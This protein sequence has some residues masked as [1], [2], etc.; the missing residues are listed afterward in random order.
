MNCQMYAH[1]LTIWVAMAIAATACT[2]VVGTTL[3][4]KGAAHIAAVLSS[5]ATSSIA[6]LTVS[7]SAGDGPSFSTMV[8]D[9]AQSGSSWTA[10]VTGIPSGS[11]RRFDVVAFDASGN[12]LY[13]GTAKANVV[14]GTDVTVSITLQ[15][16][17]PPFGTTVPVLDSVTASVFSVSPSGTVE[18]KVTAHDSDSSVT[19]GYLWSAT[20]GTFAATTGPSTTWTA[21]ALGPTTCTLSISVSDGRGATA[22]AQMNI[23]VTSA[24]SVK[25]SRLVTYWPDPDGATSTSPSEDVATAAAPVA[26]SRDAAGAWTTYEGGYLK[27]DGTLGQ[28]FGSDGSFAIPGV[29]GGTYVLCY[30]FPA[31]PEVCTDATADEVDLGY[32]VLGRPDQIAASRATPV[33]FA[34]GGL[35][36]WDPITDEMEITSSSAN[37]WDVAGARGIFRGGDT[38]GT[39]VE[40]WES[41][42]GSGSELHL[43]EQADVLYVHQLSARTIYA[44]GTML[45]Y[46]AATNA[47]GQ[48]PAGSALSGLTVGDGLPLSIAAS[49]Q[50][51]PLSASIDLDW[52]L[53]QF[54]AQLALLGPAERTS[55]GAAPHEFRVGANAFPLECPAPVAVGSPDLLQFP[56]PAGLGTVSGTLYYGRFLPP[57]WREWQEARFVA[58]VS[59][60]QAGA[61]EPLLERAG[62]TG[63]D[64]LPVASGPVVPAMTP[65]LSPQLNGADA[66][67]D[68]TGV[69]VSPTLSWSAPSTGTPTAYVV[70]VAMLGTRG[71]ATTSSTV[72]RYATSAT[73]VTVPP[74]LLATGQTYY[75][76]ITAESSTVPYSVAPFRSANAYSRA[77]TLTGTFR[78]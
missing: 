3:R 54:E 78:P 61:T 47:T 31:G 49:L 28:G 36:P 21:P 18:V 22:E 44:Q 59:Y 20:C 64:P 14:A 69:G 32:D 37:L 56:L 6:R 48:P 4:E 62:L 30:A 13:S 40:D 1:R 10:Y 65:V 26:L 2:P 43:L 41:G 8:A 9:L 19:L 68:A 39:L 7:V 75:A 63:R 34:L 29:P 66:F 70:E 27:P 72:L 77:T 11:G 55:L 53:S 5:G 58:Q 50:P 38:S 45:Y 74:G 42:N 57:L 33:T 60:L 15:A 73:Q 46:V 52:D 23:E 51:L 24:R 25:G 16:V 35:Y 71:T 17:S 67:Q 12:A 76:R